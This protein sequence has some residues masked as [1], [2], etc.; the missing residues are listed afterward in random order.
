MKKLLKTISGFLAAL[1]AVSCADDCSYWEMEGNDAAILECYAFFGT[2]NY[3]GFISP[4]SIEFCLP[5]EANPKNLS[6]QFKASEGATIDPAPESLTDWSEPVVLTV[7]SPNGK[8]QNPYRVEV[9]VSDEVELKAPVE[10]RTQTEVNEF[11]EK[12]Y[13]VLGS[14]LLQQRDTKDPIV[15][16]TPLSGIKRIEGGLEIQSIAAKTVVFESLEAVGS[17]D[18]LSLDLEEFICPGLKTVTSRFRIGN[19]DSGPMPSA[20][21]KLRKV[22]CPSLESVGGSFILFLV[23]AMEDLDLSSL[24]YVGEDFTVEGGTYADLA[25]IQNLKQVNRSLT[26]SGTFNSLE[27]FGVETIGGQFSLNVGETASLEPLSVLKK[28]HALTLSEA[29]NVTSLKGIEHVDLQVLELVSFPLVTSLEYIP[30]K[31]RMEW[32]SV[33]NFTALESLAGLEKV[34]EVGDLMVGGCSSLKNLDPIARISVE[35]SLGLVDLPCESLPAFE[36]IVSLKRGLTLSMMPEL[37]D[38]SGL[39]SLRDAADMMLYE[40]N[41]LASLKGLENLEKITGGSFLV[42]GL[43]ISDLDPLANLKEIDFGG[44]RGTIQFVANPNLES[45]CAVRE[46]LLENWKLPGDRS[47]RV[48]LIDN[49]YNPTEQQLKD[50]YC[51]PEGHG[52]E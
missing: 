13:T 43:A 32:L 42:S 16:L 21:D 7:T 5:A 52:A 36:N 2:R 12:G 27:G 25:F 46:F 15:D 38:I 33:R 26:L 50:G 3:A 1:F 45:Y 39:S 49:K 6:I 4:G 24:A 28:V 14:L 23:P 41:R 29:P 37:T 48:K 18:V 30:V 20:H 34:Q 9:V 44:Q 47:S 11:G 22:E 35:N 19:N 8:T 40:L 51:C 31:D 17:V 10:L